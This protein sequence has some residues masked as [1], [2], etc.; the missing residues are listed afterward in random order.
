MQSFTPRAADPY[1]LPPGK[2]R[3][4]LQFTATLGV[5]A[6]VATVAPASAARHT[7][8]TDRDQPLRDGCQ[9]PSFVDL[10]LVNSPEWVYV[11]HDPSVHF[12]QGVSRVVHPT[13]IDQP[14]THDWYDF[15]GN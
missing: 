3:R 7:R 5:L 10:T 4:L 14:G 13:P 12:A 2:V 15:N 9:R 11:D 1:R 8:P 6:A